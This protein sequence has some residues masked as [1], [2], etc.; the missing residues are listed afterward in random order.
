[1]SII[2]DNFDN[3]D[4]IIRYFARRYSSLKVGMEEEDLVVEGWAALLGSIE[5]YDPSLSS[6]STWAWAVV[7]N[8]YK[9]KFKWFQGKGRIKG[10]Q[11]PRLGSGEFDVEANKYDVENN[12]IQKETVDTLKSFLS[13]VAVLALD[14]RLE[15]YKLNEIQTELGLSKRDTSRVM[16]EIKCTGELIGEVL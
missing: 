6:I 1:M 13:P 8:W 14:L 7:W 11:G 15:G 12:L 9:T 16:R 2:D 4:R 3:L 10:E 5:G